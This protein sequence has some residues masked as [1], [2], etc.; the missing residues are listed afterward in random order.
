MSRDYKSSR[1]STPAK[2]K[3]RRVTRKPRR[4]SD[5]RS[6]GWV[7]MLCGLGL[8]LSIAVGSYFLMQAPTA[9]AIVEKPVVK[10][11]ARAKPSSE[12]IKET[13]T[14]SEKPQFDFYT[15]LP[16]MEVVIPDSVIEE[17]NRALPQAATNLAYVL[18]TGSFR[19]AADADTMKAQ[20]ALIGIEADVE[21]VVINDSDTW[22]RVRLGPFPDM[23]SLKPVRRQLKQNDIDFILLKMKI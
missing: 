19:N 20:L 18:Q 15:L 7:W 8:G 22:H 6:P 5:R 14:E 9:T 11:T 16:K 3:R 2:K 17:A 23:T 21:T 12:K 13:K 4:R 10:K 1:R